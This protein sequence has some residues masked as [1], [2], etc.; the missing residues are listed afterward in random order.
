MREC[1]HAARGARVA[2]REL[3]RERPLQ[4]QPE[5]GQVPPFATMPAAAPQQAPFVPMMP[6]Q[7]QFPAMT[8]HPSIRLVQEQ[9]RRFEDECYQ[10]AKDHP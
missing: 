3:T 10:N 2:L 1:Q 6:A 9:L 5:P 4:M 7:A 8:S